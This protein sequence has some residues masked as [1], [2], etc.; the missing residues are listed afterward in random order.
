MG[1]QR[2]NAFRGRTLALAFLLTLDFPGATPAN[3]GRYSVTNLVTDNQAINSAKITDP[4][5]VNAWGISSSSTSPFWI[6]DNGRGVSTLYSVEPTNNLTSIVPLVVTIPGDGT[7][8]GQVFNSAN[9]SGAFNQNLFLFVSQDGTISGWRGAS[10]TTAETL[11]LPDASNVYKGATLETIGSHSYLLSAN[12][13]TGNIDVLKGDAGAPGL[14]GR[15]TD[16]GL[17]ANYA[18]FN[19]QKLGNTIYVTYA[20]QDAAKHDDVAGAGHGFV[21]AFD[22]NGTFLARVSGGGTL[23]SPWGLAI[24]PSTFGKFAGDLLVGNFGDGHINVFDPT[25][26][27]FLGQLNGLDGNPLSI[28]GLWALTPGNDHGAGSSQSIYFTAGPVNESHG[29]FGVIES[30][31]EPSTAVMSLIALG[32]VAAGCRYRNRKYRAVA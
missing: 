28:D 21:S 13:R 19:V 23:N 32:L 5:L 15:F 26:N 24:A 25:N 2:L 9:A 11:Q 14:A 12:F 10:G 20:L 29:L 6:S 8:T 18:P 4:N 16:P 22:S 17:P 1:W 30:V 31:P 3:A 27:K 7:P